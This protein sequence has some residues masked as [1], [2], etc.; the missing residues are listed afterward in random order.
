MFCCPTTTSSW[1]SVKWY[2][3]EW[4][5]SQHDRTGQAVVYN[6]EG[7]GVQV[8]SELSVL[9]RL[10][11]LNMSQ[12]GQGLYKCEVTGPAPVYH[13]VTIMNTV[14]VVKLPHKPPLVEVVGQAVSCTV[15]VQEN[16]LT[17]MMWF[18]DGYTAPSSWVKSEYN[19]SL[20]TIRQGMLGKVVVRC[21]ARVDQ[22]YWGAAEVLV[23]VGINAGYGYG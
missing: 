3:E 5:L 12:S 6:R 2:K 13:T 4:Q 17:E 7:S 1:F 16:I 18:I 9:G 23:E 15:Q 11:L 8:D 21:V 22:M 19:K 14:R 20:I 10:V